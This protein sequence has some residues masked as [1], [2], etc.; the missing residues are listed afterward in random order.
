MANKKIPCTLLFYCC[1]VKKSQYISKKSALGVKS[2]S[3]TVQTSIVWV[4]EQPEL[5]G[6]VAKKKSLLKQKCHM[7]SWLQFAIRLVGGS[8]DWWD[9]NCYQIKAS[10]ESR[11]LTMKLGGGGGG[12]IMLCKC[13]L[14][15]CLQRLVMEK[16]EFSKMQGNPDGVSG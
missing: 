9:Q 7:T 6:R 14:S 15:A 1:W 16:G 11:H 13:F 3:E 5:Y 4:L 2:F 10:S 12:S 8:V